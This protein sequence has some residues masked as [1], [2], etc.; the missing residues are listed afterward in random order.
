MKE[1]VRTHFFLSRVQ[2][3]IPDI[4]HASHDLRA[5]LMLACVELSPG[6]PLQHGGPAHTEGR[7]QSQARD[8]RAAGL[9]RLALGMLPQRKLLCS[10]Y[11]L[12]VQS[13]HFCF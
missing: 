10:P 13:Q 8:A 6:A 12:S 11:N 5:P 7:V 4:D 3:V 9:P 2:A 1:Y